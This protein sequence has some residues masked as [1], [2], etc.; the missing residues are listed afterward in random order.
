MNIMK[1]I[2]SSLKLIVLVVVITINSIHKLLEV[3]LIPA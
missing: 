1:T 2:L 3:L